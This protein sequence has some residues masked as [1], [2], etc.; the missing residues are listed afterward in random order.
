MQELLFC[1]AIFSYLRSTLPQGHV[2]V[3]FWMFVCHCITWTKLW[4]GFS[5]GPSTLGV[6]PGLPTGTLFWRSLLPGGLGALHMWNLEFHKS[7]IVEFVV[8]SLW[9]RSLWQQTM[10][11]LCVDGHPLVAFPYPYSSC[12]ARRRRS[13]PVL[14][15]QWGNFQSYLAILPMCVLVPVWAYVCVHLSLSGGAGPYEGLGGMS[16]YFIFFI[17]LHVS[18]F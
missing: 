17:L 15:P 8:G 9:Q 1:L 7:G 12:H 16:F 14:I 5:W 13:I 6:V 11:P 3:T 4:R 18:A 10:V 2:C